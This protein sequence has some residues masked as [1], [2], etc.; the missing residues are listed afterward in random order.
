MVNNRGLTRNGRSIAVTAGG[1][2]NKSDQD[3]II[4]MAMI[5]QF[6]MT[7]AAARGAAMVADD[8]VDAISN[9]IPTATEAIKRNTPGIVNQVVDVGKDITGAFG[10]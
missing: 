6:F 3:A 8:I 5:G 7:Y 10:L 4:Y 9:P 2:L 1:N